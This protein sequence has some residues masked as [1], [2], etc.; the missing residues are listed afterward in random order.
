MLVMLIY[1]FPIMK[2]MA[3]QYN[4]K[5]V[6]GFENIVTCTLSPLFADPGQSK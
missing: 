1:F 4:R 6:L 5:I 3:G 2:A